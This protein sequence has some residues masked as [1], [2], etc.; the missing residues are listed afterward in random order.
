[1]LFKQAAVEIWDHSLNFV[2]SMKISP[3]VSSFSWSQSDGEEEAFFVTSADPSD[4]QISRVDF[5]RYSNGKVEQ[6][7]ETAIRTQGP[8]RTI[9][10]LRSIAAVADQSSLR[11]V[12][13]KSGNT[14]V[15][16]C[17]RRTTGKVITEAV[18]NANIVAAI[19]EN[20]DIICCSQRDEKWVRSIGGYI[21][22]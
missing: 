22:Y 8:I 4:G 12:S 2:R 11:V 10:A 20:G 19:M 15:P 21:F 1:M 5:F 18:G 17:D 14:I 7:R 3:D 6:Q 16:L 13:L 9:S